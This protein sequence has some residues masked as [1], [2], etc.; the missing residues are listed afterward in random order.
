MGLCAFAAQQSTCKTM[1]DAFLLGIKTHLRKHR[2]PTLNGYLLIAKAQKP[3]HPP[4]PCPSSHWFLTAPSFFRVQGRYVPVTSYQGPHFSLQAQP[5]HNETFTQRVSLWRHLEELVLSFFFFW[6][7]QNP[8]TSCPWVTGCR[9]SPPLP[10]PDPWSKEIHR[11]TVIREEHR[12]N[13]TLVGASS[14]SL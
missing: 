11:H 14:S 2:C 8:A 3:L 13:Q 5:F 9:A 1:F 12:H 10:P 7:I 6:G 4:I